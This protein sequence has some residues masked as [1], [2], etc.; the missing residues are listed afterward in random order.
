MTTT[1]EARRAYLLGCDGIRKAAYAEQ[2]GALVSVWDG[3]AQGMDTEGGRWSTVC[4]GHGT[5][6]AHETLTLAL[7]HS[8]DPLGWCEDCRDDLPAD[9]THL[10]KDPEAPVK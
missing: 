5:I 7:S 4:E 10:D 8:A 2:N 9:L 6:I 3:E 1:R